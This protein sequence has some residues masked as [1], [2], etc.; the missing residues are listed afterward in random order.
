MNPCAF[1]R[2]SASATALEKT[3]LLPTLGTG[4]RANLTTTGPADGSDMAPENEAEIFHLCQHDPGCTERDES[5][6]TNP[7]ISS[8]P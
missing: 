4:F 6:A 7:G 3:Q 1:P 2:A 8:Q 5:H